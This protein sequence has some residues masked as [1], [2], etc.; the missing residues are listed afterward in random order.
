[1]DNFITEFTPLAQFLSNIASIL[2]AVFAI[3]GVRQVYL[4]KQDMDTR[5]ERASKEKAIEFCGRY[6]S[7]YT[8]L[9]D[10]FFLQCQASK[11]EDYKGPLG[12][13]SFSSVPESEKEAAWK[14]FDITSWIPALN[15]LNAI[16]SAFVTGVADEKVGFEII[17]RSFCATVS[18]KYCLLALSRQKNA[19]DYFQGIIDLY[20]IWA[21]R[22]SKAELE[23]ASE[24]INRRLSGI[25]DRS[26]PAIGSS[27]P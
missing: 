22:M 1:M 11:V 21:P 16:S 24:Q 3:Y 15:E 10:T 18:D 26:I 7:V 4:L 25:N 20:E 23:A 9:D 6:F 12:D 19:L 13:F 27:K 14:L 17:G 8:P 2:V 5:N